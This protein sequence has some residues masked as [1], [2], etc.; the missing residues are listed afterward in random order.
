MESSDLIRK[1]KFLSL[2]LRHNPGKIGLALDEHGWA[3]I[4]EL[5]LKLERAEFPLDRSTLAQTV[6]QNDK[7]R[8]AFSADGQKIRA[9][10]GHSLAVDLELQPVSPP[11]VLYHGTALRFQPSIL[12]NG[13]LPGSRMYVHLSID[14]ATARSVGQRHGKPIL[15]LVQARLMEQDGYS[16]FLSANGVWLTAS[17]PPRY[18]VLLPEGGS[19]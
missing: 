3:D 14:K 11:D 9:S 6:E 10:Q 5:L 16:F 18:L 1:S 8:Y 12:E 15:F 2:I 17:V 13:L 7:N 19:K 4:E